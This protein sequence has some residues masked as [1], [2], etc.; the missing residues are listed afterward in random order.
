MPLCLLQ[1]AFQRVDA[2]LPLGFLKWRRTTPTSST[3]SAFRGSGVWRELTLRFH[4]WGNRGTEKSSAFPSPTG[5]R[6]QEAGPGKGPLLAVFLQPAC[7]RPG[8]RA[9]LSGARPA[10]A[11]KRNALA[12]PC[13]R[14]LA[15]EQ[16][17][18]EEPGSGRC[19]P[20]QD[21]L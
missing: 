21:S 15:P 4:R 19:E 6:I 11:C 8:V 3:L 7:A 17:L 12:R 5:T 20:R 14:V 10:S 2:P 13:P 16:L 1:A 18:R 9:A